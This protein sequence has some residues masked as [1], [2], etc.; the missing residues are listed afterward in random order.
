MHHPDIFKHVH[1]V[2]Q[3][4]TNP[5]PWT[6]YAFHPL[7]AI[8]EVSIVP[9]IAFALPVHHGSLTLFFIIQ[10]FINVYGHLGYEIYP[11]GFNKHWLGKWINTSVAHN[12]HHKDFDGNYGLY[13]LFWDRWMG[14]LRLDY[15]WLYE[16]TT[17]DTDTVVLKNE[18]RYAKKSALAK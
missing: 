2:H 16:A 18:K 1:L 9:L 3:K 13:F 10:V 11:Q 4:S 5:S 7:E 15:D 6:A 8:V 12:Q 14:I 17:Q